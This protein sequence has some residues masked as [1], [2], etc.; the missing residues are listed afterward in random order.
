M[1]NMSSL[2]CFLLSY[3]F[4]LMGH[5]AADVAVGV[6]EQLGVGVDRD[7]GLEVAMALDQVHN[8][9]HLDLRVSIGAVV[10]FG[11]GEAAGTGAWTFHTEM[12]YAVMQNY[13]QMSYNISLKCKLA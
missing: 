12:I 10:G 11:A 8:V 1:A 3:K 9:L 13:R 5:A 6:H 7:E 4:S 2:L